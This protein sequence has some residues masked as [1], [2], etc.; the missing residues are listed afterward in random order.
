MRH[1]VGAGNWAYDFWKSSQC[2]WLLG[3]S[4]QPLCLVLKWPYPAFSCV[5]WGCKLR[6]ALQ[7]F[8]WPVHLPAPLLNFTREGCWADIGLGRTSGVQGEKRNPSSSVAQAQVT[9]TVWVTDGLSLVSVLAWGIRFSTLELFL[10]TPRYHINAQGEA[11]NLFLSLLKV[12][13][14]PYGLRHLTSHVTYC[15]QFGGPENWFSR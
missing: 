4:L 9:P 5:C 8:Y 3:V 1:L 6:F 15:H 2:S 7:A 13:A 12:S 11:A 14:C 10:E